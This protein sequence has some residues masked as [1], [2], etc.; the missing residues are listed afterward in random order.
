[1]TVA[2]RFFQWCFKWLHPDI[3]IKIAHLWS[4]RSRAGHD[5]SKFKELDEEWLVRYSR[6]KLDDQFFDYFVFGHRHF[7]VSYQIAD[8]STY[9][10]LGDWIDNNTYGILDTERLSLETFE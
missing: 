6:R 5:I 9:I 2:N 10:N 3:G 4:G 8:G 1:M 7:P